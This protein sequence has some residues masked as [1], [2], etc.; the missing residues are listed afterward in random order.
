MFGIT[1]SRDLWP[2]LVLGA[3]VLIFV[4]GFLAWRI[5]NNRNLQTYDQQTFAPQ[6][7]AT[8]VQFETIDSKVAAAVRDAEVS[9]SEI[10][11]MLRL[12]T[13]MAGY[14]PMTDPAKHSKNFRKISAA[15]SSFMTPGVHNMFVNAFREAAPIDMN[16][17]QDIRPLSVITGYPLEVLAK[18]ESLLTVMVTYA[19]SIA[20][21]YRRNADNPRFTAEFLGDVSMLVTLDKFVDINRTFYTTADTAQN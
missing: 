6:R 19:P 4:F 17:R 21:F 16:N 2:Y 13:A 11:A 10:F 8:P 9:I 1:V 20:E 15:A 18:R 5:R 3:S 12:I 7:L 14:G